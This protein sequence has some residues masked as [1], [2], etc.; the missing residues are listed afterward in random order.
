MDGNVAH[1]GTRNRDSTAIQQSDNSCAQQ[2][3]PPSKSSVPK[4][5]LPSKSKSGR[6]KLGGPNTCVG[7]FR[8]ARFIRRRNRYNRSEL[9]ST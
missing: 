4:A 6:L 1:L 2:P 7:G 8:H 9:A 5:W 3:S